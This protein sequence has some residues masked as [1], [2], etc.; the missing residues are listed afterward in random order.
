MPNTNITFPQNPTQ[1]QQY[2]YGSITYIYDGTSWS[3]DS[4]IV[5]SPLKLDST[6]NRVGINN[7]S[8]TVELDV[9][10]AIK[11]STTLAITG[12]TTLSS[13]LNV[14]G[15]TTLSSN[16]TVGTNT[17]FVNATNNRVGIGT[18]SPSA[19]L[20]IASSTGV[21]FGT[22]PQTQGTSTITT[23]TPASPVSSRFT[24]G[25]DGLGWQYRI[26]KNQS[27]TI[28]DLV[29]VT[30]NGR[31]GIGTTAPATTLDLG[32]G[33]QIK[34]PATANAS[35]DANTLDDYKEGSH[36]ILNTDFGGNTQNGTYSLSSGQNTIHY[37]KIGNRLFFTGRFALSAITTAGSGQIR[38]K[39]L[40]FSSSEQGWATCYWSSL[41]ATAPLPTNVTAQWLGNSLFFYKTTTAGN[42]SMTTLNPA[43]L[44]AA[45]TIHFT[46]HCVI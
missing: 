8:P 46:G 26:A 11:G 40:P 42:A 1:G 25:T 17:L 12:G 13:T 21:V 22:N 31:V 35:S 41:S 27:G 28:T 37:V 32:T 4:T 18:T 29:T 14:T 16:L 38:I 20:Q 33:G 23:A 9:T 7:T 19:C 34:F 5:S 43:D 30:D 10:G 24:F 6:N 45:T 3:V 36:V 39:N 2:P 15:A 44:T